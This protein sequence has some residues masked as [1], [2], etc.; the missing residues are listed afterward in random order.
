MEKTGTKQ[1]IQVLGLSK[2]MF[3]SFG[4]KPGQRNV[5]WNM[6]IAYPSSVSMHLITWDLLMLLFPRGMGES[7]Q[8][9]LQN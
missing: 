4:K 9:I 8:A 2:A 1:R 5:I 7:V 3:Y 6:Q